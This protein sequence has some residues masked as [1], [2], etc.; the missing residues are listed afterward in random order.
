M[1]G[2]AEQLDLRALGRI[3]TERQKD[4][5]RNAGHARGPRNALPVIAG[6]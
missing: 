5:R 2:R 3:R 1:N 6:R 4:V